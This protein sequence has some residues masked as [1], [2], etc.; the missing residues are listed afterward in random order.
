M[1]LKFIQRTLVWWIPLAIA[2][3]LLAGLG[4]DVSWMKHAV[5]PLTILMI[6]PMMVTLDYSILLK[7]WNIKLHLVT[8]AINFIVLPALSYLLIK[9]FFAGYP[10]F[11]FAML[12]IA[13]IPTSAMTISWTG[14]A[15]GNVDAAVKMSIFGLILGTLLAPIYIRLILGEA[16]TIPFSMFFSRIALLIGIPMILGYA[17][18]VY[19]YRK[20]WFE[21]HSSRFPPLSS[22]GVLAIIIVSVSMKAQVLIKEPMILVVALIPLILFYVFAF[23]VSTLVGMMFSLADRT[24]LVFGTA[25]RNLSLVLALCVTLIDSHLMVILI[26]LAFMIQIKTAAWYAKVCA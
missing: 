6:Y 22:I 26:S 13:L 4:F 10:E 11:A 12:L 2:I 19:L 17:T 16:I 7:S 9:I 15:K 18:Q 5:I 1:V 25:V 3:G 21:K 8:Q 20:G 24:A 23:V 14:I